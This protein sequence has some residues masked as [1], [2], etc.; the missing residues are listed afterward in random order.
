MNDM[1]SINLRFDL[2]YIHTYIHAYVN[3][4]KNK[5]GGWFAGL[6][7]GINIDIDIHSSYQVSASMDRSPGAVMILSPFFLVYI[8]NRNRRK[9]KKGE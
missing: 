7:G 5:K 3:S 2:I 4:K 1:V 9:V 6:A 8:Y